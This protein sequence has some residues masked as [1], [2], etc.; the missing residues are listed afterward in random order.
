VPSTGT[1][2]EFTAS[3]K[4]LILSV[5][6]SGGGL[7]G[8]PVTRKSSGR[9]LFGGQFLD[10]RFPPAKDISPSRVSVCTLRLFSATSAIHDFAFRFSPPVLVPIHMHRHYCCTSLAFYGCDNTV[11]TIVSAPRGGRTTSLFSHLL[12]VPQSYIWGCGG[13]GDSITNG[14]FPSIVKGSPFKAI[15]RAS[16]AMRVDSGA[17]GLTDTSIPVPLQFSSMYGVTTHL[18]SV[19]KTY[20]SRITSCIVSVSMENWLNDS[21]QCLTSIF[22]PPKGLNQE[23]KPSLFLPNKRADLEPCAASCCCSFRTSNSRFAVRSSASPTCCLTN[24]S[25]WSLLL[26]NSAPLPRRS[27][28]LTRNEPL[29]DATSMP[30]PSS[31]AIPSDIRETLAISATTFL[32]EGLPGNLAMPRKNAMAQDSMSS[33]H[34]CRMTQNSIATPSRTTEENHKTECSQ[35]TDELSRVLI[36]LSRADMDLSKAEMEL[37]KA[38]TSVGSVEAIWSRDAKITIVLLLALV[39]YWCKPHNP[40]IE[41]AP[42]PPRPTPLHPQPAR[43]LVLAIP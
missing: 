30:A 7:F 4:N 17:S 35:G 12:L 20:C 21:R 25:N 38:E 9:F 8:R 2:V 42:L 31:P 11:S 16:A 41:T 39:V 24:A 26:R 29:M 36:S 22:W 33:R 6:S 37:S 14:L 3:R 32:A 5:S 19:S 18:A 28:P 23:T 10:G 27:A 40:S 34:S 15:H 43:V 1:K 13:R